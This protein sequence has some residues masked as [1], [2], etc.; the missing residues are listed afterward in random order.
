MPIAELDNASPSEGEDC[1][2]ESRWARQDS[3][4][5][6]LVLVYVILL[7]CTQRILYAYNFDVIDLL[8][9]ADRM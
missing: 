4:I 7:H 3:V 6:F 9:H 5:I 8:C 1:G 2:F